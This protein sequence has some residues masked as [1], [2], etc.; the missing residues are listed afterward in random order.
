MYD[1][2]IQRAPI[3]LAIIKGIAT[4]KPDP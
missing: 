4:A 2:N 1:A 3:G